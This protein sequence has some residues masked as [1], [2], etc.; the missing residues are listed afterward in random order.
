MS[1]A[2]C[3]D[4]TYSGR[5]WACNPVLA[6]RVNTSRRET[7][8]TEDTH[9][10]KTAISFSVL[11]DLREGIVWYGAFGTRDETL[12]GHGRGSSTVRVDVL[13]YGNAQTGSYCA[14]RPPMTNHEP[15]LLWRGNHNGSTLQ[16]CSKRYCTVQYTPKP[17]ISRSNPNDAVLCQ[18]LHLSLT[19]LNQ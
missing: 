13:N 3:V 4:G 19:E 12:E 9:L 5:R 7:R 15:K 14:A 6:S 1:T 11:E 17:H 8:Y 16:T 10:L 2:S 18:D